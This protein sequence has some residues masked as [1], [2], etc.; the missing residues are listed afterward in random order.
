MGPWPMRFSLWFRST[1]ARGFD[2][3][4]DLKY[5]KTHWLRPNGE[6]LVE[7]S[8]GTENSAGSVPSI[9]NRDLAPVIP[10]DAELVHF[11]ADYIHCQRGVSNFEER[12]YEAQDW[13]YDNC[14]ID[15][16]DPVL[17][18]PN[19]D[20][21]GHD[22][23]ANVARSIINNQREGEELRASFNRAFNVITVE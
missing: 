6:V 18:D 2:G 14:H 23:V 8:P 1:R 17:R 12:L 20:R 22:W 19:R 3:M 13:V 4:V 11:Y 5:H 21:F 7:H 15:Q 9:D 16:K 10:A